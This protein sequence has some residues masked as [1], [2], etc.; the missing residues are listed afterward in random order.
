M[1]PVVMERWLRR[2]RERLEADDALGE[3]YHLRGLSEEERSLLAAL[4]RRGGLT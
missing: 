2:V 4:E 1:T 3:L